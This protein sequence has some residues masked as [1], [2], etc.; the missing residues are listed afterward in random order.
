VPH[1]VGAPASVAVEMLL[2]PPAQ[3][4]A[5]CSMECRVWFEELRKP[6]GPTAGSPKISSDGGHRSFCST[7]AVHTG[8]VGPVVRATRN[9][10][11]SMSSCATPELGYDAIVTAPRR[12]RKVRARMTPRAWGSVARA[13]HDFDTDASPRPTIVRRATRN[14]ARTQV[15]RHHPCHA[16]ACA[17]MRR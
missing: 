7:S 13:G 11:W 2:S 9:C 17:D 5:Q 15:R 8:R 10:R 14:L 1:V 4:R 12:T 3:S 6:R 16:I